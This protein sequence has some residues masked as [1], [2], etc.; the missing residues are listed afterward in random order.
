MSSTPTEG[1]SFGIGPPG[2]D[3]LGIVS[4][5]QAYRAGRLSPV[6]VV[7]LI[8]G[9]IA[10]RGEDGVWIA[11]DLDRA[12]AAAEAL[13]AVADPHRPLWGIPFAVKDN[14]DVAG[15]PTTAGCPAFAY[16]AENSATAVQRLLEAGAI[17]IGKTNLDQFATGLNGT[18][19]PFGIPR[20]VA[21]DTMISGGSSSGSAVAVAAGLVSF[22]LGTDTAGSGRVPAALNGIVGFKPSRGLVSTAGVVPACRSLDCV[23]VFALTVDDAADVVDLMGGM[24]EADPW[25]RPLPRPVGAPRPTPSE[26]RLAIPSALEFEGEHGYEF[27][28]LTALERLRSE[29][30]E[31]VEI[32]FR[33]FLEAGRLL[34]DGPWVAER[35]SATGAFL[36]DHSGEV[37]PVVRR[38]VTRGSDYSGADVFEGMDRLQVLRRDAALTLS[39]VDALL[40]P[41]TPTTF[42]VDEML[43]DPIERN[44]TL[45]R[46]TTYGNLLDLAVVAL[47]ARG[48][49]ADRP[50]GVSLAALAGSDAM[51][52]AIAGVL[53]RVLAGAP[54]A[55]APWSANT[56][57]REVRS[58]E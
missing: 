20:A 32:E 4:L 40:T 35:F 9:R 11:L 13:G 3:D 6:D 24:D 7:R 21:D 57:E 18:R 26:L 10:A 1:Q 23:N 28:W 55:E 8:G 44:A 25:T 33:V 54:E 27:A 56:V 51:L 47:P 58:R 36:R 31:I 53:S 14:I 17:M 37:D 52:G 45:G 22:A 5:T 29:G 16:D 42:S 2:I 39:G 48:A 38:V 50:F 43:A 46:F 34:Y 30:V 41:T 19:S 15:W 49:H 12:L